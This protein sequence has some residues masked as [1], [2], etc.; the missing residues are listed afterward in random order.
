MRAV[1][2]VRLDFVICENF[3]V[4]LLGRTKLANGPMSVG[5]VSFDAIWFVFLLAAV[6]PF[7]W[8]DDEPGMGIRLPTPLI[9]IRD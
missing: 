7:D 2:F 6:G 9:G 8:E 1:K 3:C 4:T 5:R